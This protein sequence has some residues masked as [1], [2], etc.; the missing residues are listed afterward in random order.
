MKYTK[1]ELRDTR[2]PLLKRIQRQMDKQSESLFDEDISIIDKKN[3]KVKKTR[4]GLYEKRR[5]KR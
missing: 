5:G 3:K 1:S 4:L 2:M